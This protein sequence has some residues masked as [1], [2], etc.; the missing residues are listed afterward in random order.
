MVPIFSQQN[1]DVVVEAITGSGKT[2][3]Y[4]IPV[5]EILLKRRD[6]ALKK[7]EI[8][9]LIISPTREL[10]QQIFEHIEM[11]LQKIAELKG[12]LF[13]GGTTVNDDMKQFETNGGNI[14]VG[15]AGR[16]DDIFNRASTKL[17]MKNNLKSLVIVNKITFKIK[18]LSFY[19]N[20]K[21][22]F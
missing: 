16:L 22:K 8:A 19:L 11:F 17:N 7:H 10:A 18:Q 14:V 21:R 1:K 3:A 20:I 9:A 5:L 13:V 6:K 2:L 12:V 15:T 4:V